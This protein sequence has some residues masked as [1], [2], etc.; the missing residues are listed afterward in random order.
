VNL[1]RYLAALP[2]PG[3][4]GDF[5][6]LQRAVCV[7]EWDNIPEKAHRFIKG[8]ILYLFPTDDARQLLL[9]ENSIEDFGEIHRRYSKEQLV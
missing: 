9:C 2:K 3:K 4:I 6:S 7:S 1:S 5:C 8:A